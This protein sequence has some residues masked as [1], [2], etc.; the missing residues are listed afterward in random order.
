MTDA[1]HCLKQLNK[2]DVY[3]S[4]PNISSAGHHTLTRLIAP[5]LRNST[6]STTELSRFS[7]PSEHPPSTTASPQDPLPTLSLTKPPQMGGIG[8]VYGATLNDRSHVVLK[9]ANRPVTDSTV[10]SEASVYDF[11]SIKASDI[12]LPQFYGLWEGG[13]NE[14]G[15][16][17]ILEDVGQ[18]LDGDVKEEPVQSRF[19]L[20]FLLFSLLSLPSLIV[21]PSSL[22]R[23]E[24]LFSSL[25]K[26]H[27]A[28]ITHEDFVQRNIVKNS[29]GDLRII[30]LS[31]A[32]LHVC[33]G[34]EGGCGELREA[35]KMLGL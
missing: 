17:L 3:F 7:F 4:F 12:P 28:G 24:R 14:D 21:C 34:E 19:A 20:A 10:V 23:S 33:E 32:E 27:Q 22:L 18:P 5:P 35:R 8:T 11:L 31:H 13:F 29:D 2:I 1:N 9:R 6:P 26:L 25:L 15:K 16:V 30:D